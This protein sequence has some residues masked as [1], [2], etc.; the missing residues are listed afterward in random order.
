MHI[1]AT[2]IMH[3]AFFVGG[4]Y[5]IM[6]SNAF[7]RTYKGYRSDYETLHSAMVLSGI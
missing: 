4:M 2:T 1:C 5:G 7:N 6:H 3:A